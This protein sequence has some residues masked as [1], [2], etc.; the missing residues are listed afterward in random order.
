MTIQRYFS[1]L[2]PLLV[3][4][5]GVL[6]SCQKNEERPY[7]VSSEDRYPTV[8]NNPLLGVA[9]KYAAGETVPVELQFA[10]QS[11]PIQEIR[12]FQRIEPAPDSAL[13]QTLPGSQAAYSRRKFAD[14]LVVRLVLPSGPNKARV[15]F[16]AAVVSQ[17]G[18]T[19]VRAIPFRLAEATPTVRVVSATNVTAPAGTA[20]VAGDVVRYSLL[21]NE[22]GISAYPERPAAPPAAT[23]VLFNNLDSLITYVRVGAAPERRLARQRLPAAGAQTG[24]ATTVAVA[25][26]LPA[27]AAGQDVV[28]RFE[29]K[30]RYLG[31][32]NFRASSATAAPITLG[33]PTPLAPV[34]SQTLTYTGSTGGDLAAFDLTTVT[35][36]AAADPV[37]SKDLVI[38]STAG[39]AVQIKAL[40]TN[41]RLVRAPANTYP[42]ATLNSIRQAYSTAAAA[43]QVTTLDNVVVG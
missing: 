25:V 24:A 17:N 37:T 2:A 39:N 14:T 42:S 9:T 43:T 18:L 41:T 27:G 28:F 1:R 6:A 31:T 38:S 16:S 7:A 32:P 30:S 23:A 40:S 36:V 8:L 4:A 21:L 15:R 22:N 33:S 29:A 11:A 34:R 19:K 3:V 5:G 20:L 13:V 12:I 10:G 26:T 35:T